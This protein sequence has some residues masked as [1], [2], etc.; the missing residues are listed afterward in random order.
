MHHFLSKRQSF[1]ADIDSI[2]SHIRLRKSSAVARVGSR[3]IPML[4]EATW[5]LD[6]CLADCCLVQ[7]VATEGKTFC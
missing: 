7:N 6:S 4:E 5:A 3:R 2:S 1:L